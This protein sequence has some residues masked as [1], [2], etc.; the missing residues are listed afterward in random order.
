ML[1]SFRLLIH[2]LSFGEMFC[3]RYQGRS[4]SGA[5]QPHIVYLLLFEK[6]DC[7]FFQCLNESV[8]TS[9]W[10]FPGKSQSLKLNIIL[11]SLVRLRFAFNSGC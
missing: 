5:W 7:C 1:V 8:A 4:W 3:K 11:T 2:A 10:Q 6:V 9:F